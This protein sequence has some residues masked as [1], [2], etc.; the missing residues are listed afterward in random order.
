ML[1]KAAVVF[2]AMTVLGAGGVVAYTVAANSAPAE[3]EAAPAIE[4]VTNLD[5]ELQTST[6]TLA[7]PVQ[8]EPQPQAD[9]G[10]PWSALGT[11]SALDETGTGFTMDTSD[12]ASLFVELGPPTY[13]QSL[14]VP[15]EAGDV[16]VVDGFQMDGQYHAGT[17]T[18][19]DGQQLVLRS[20]LGQPLW[21]GSVQNAD[22]GNGLQDGSHEPQPQ[23]QVNEW[24]T[25]TGTLIEMFGNTYTIQTEVGDLLTISAGAPRRFLDEQ[26]FAA[27]IGDALTFTYFENNGSY[28]AGD[29]TNETTGARLMLRDPNGRPLWAGPGRGNSNGNGFASTAVS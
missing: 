17:I 15:L 27:N 16:V 2:L 14:G 11:I 26:G 12:G 19:P 23:A 3:A 10:A 5:A 28:S 25:V 4:P 13:W 7:V 1:K 24:L 8:P 9:V 22:A 29:I 18:K 6:D 20:E 21:A